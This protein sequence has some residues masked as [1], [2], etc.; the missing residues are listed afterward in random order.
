M[1]YTITNIVDFIIAKFVKEAKTLLLTFSATEY[2]AVYSKLFAPK[3][4]MD[5]FYKWTILLLTL[6]TIYSL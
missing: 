1:F 5:L 2:K 4:S 3:M 6:P